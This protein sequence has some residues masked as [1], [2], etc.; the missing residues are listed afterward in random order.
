MS[1][2][3]KMWKTNEIFHSLCGL[4]F[5]FQIHDGF[6]KQDNKNIILFS[7]Y[8]KTIFNHKK[9]EKQRIVLQ[10]LPKF[11]QHTK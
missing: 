3:G 6:L 9:Y 11:Q 10:S 8:L 1:I 2:C 4:M 5:F 7:K